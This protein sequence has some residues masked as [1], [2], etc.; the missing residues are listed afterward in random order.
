[1]SAY[2]VDKLMTEARRLAADY[3]K[4]TGQTLPLTNEIARHDAMRL[5]Q[6]ENPKES[7]AGVDAVG[8]S[9]K[10]SEKYQI[11][12]R[13]MFAESK[14]RTRI[15]QL[16]LDGAW[17][18]VVLVLMNE[19]YQPTE[20]IEVTRADIQNALNEIKPNKRGAMTIAKFRSLG[21]SVWHQD[22]QAA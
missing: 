15:G 16:N 20:I 10:S 1:M 14:A 19:D 18:I 7:L 22:K 12:G 3:H 8:T 21:T 9:E 17:T 11:K 6:L 5:L 2:D 4:A 13:V